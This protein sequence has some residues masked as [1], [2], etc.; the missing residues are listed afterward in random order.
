MRGPDLISTYMLPLLLVLMQGAKVLSFL[1]Y[2]TPKNFVRKP[3]SFTI[4]Y[5]RAPKKSRFRFSTEVIA[6][7]L[8]NFPIFPHLMLIK[9]K[10]RLV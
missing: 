4:V 5:D 7:G 10:F 8:F 3:N 6:E 1:V 9:K 2:R